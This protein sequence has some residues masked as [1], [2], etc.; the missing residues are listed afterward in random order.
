MYD[1][2]FTIKQLFEKINWKILESPKPQLM[3]GDGVGKGIAVQKVRGMGGG[4]E[5]NGKNGGTV[6]GHVGTD[7]DGSRTCRVVW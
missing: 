3:H 1:L 2:D 6:M 7:G 5:Q 4:W